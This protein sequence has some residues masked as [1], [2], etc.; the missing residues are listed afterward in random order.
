MF[1]LHSSNKT[2]NL[3]AHLVAIMGNKPLSSPFAKEVFLIQSQGMER[4]LSQQLAAEFKVWGNYSF[5]FPGKF[6]SSLAQKIDSRLSDAAFERHVMQWRLEALLRDL[7][8]AELAVLNRYLSGTNIGLK[9]YQLAQQLSQLFDQYQMMRPD[10]LALWQQNK[11]LY[12][13][14]TERWQ[15]KLWLQVLDKT[16]PRHRGVLWQA[17]IAKLNDAPADKF[18]AVMPERISV[19]G[20]NTMP[21]LFLHYL[22]GLARHCDVH[23]YLLNPAQEFWAD[24]QG[25][26]QRALDEAVDGHPLLATLGQQGREF[27][28]MLLEENLAFELELD[29]F[30]AIDTPAPSLLQRLQNDILNNAPEAVAIHNNDR[31]ISLHSCHSRLREVEVLKNQLLQSLEAD[32]A[33]ELRDIVVMAPDIQ[34]Y[35]P[36]IGAV[37]ADIQHAIADRSLRLS[38]T[39][40]DAF[41]RF[42]S[43]SQSRFGWVTV[44]DLLEQPVVYPSFG[45]SETDLELVKHWVHDTQVRWGKSAQH[46][47]ELGLP[48]QVENT[49]QAA[50]DRL[51]MGYAV[52]DAGD[53]VDGILPYR[54]IEGASAQAL[55]GLCDFIAVLFRAS[56]DLKQPKTLQNWSQRLYYYADQ[57]LQAAEALERQQ[58]N[59]VLVELSADLAAVHNETV[60]LQ[61]IISWIEG[62]VSERKSSNGFLRGQLTFCSMLPMRSIPFKVIALL[63]MNDGEFPKIDRPP[64]F[65]L[66]GMKNHFRKGDRSRRA[67]DRY[68]FLEILLSTRQQLLVTYIGQSISDNA[69]IPPS[70]II[71]ELLDVLQDSYQLTDVVT[72]HPLQPF[73]A[74]YFTGDERLFSFSAGDFKTAQQL[75]AR[76][77]PPAGRT[78]VWWQGAVP[79]T[80]DKVLELGE[81]LRFFRHPQ[82]Y[83]MQRQLDIRLTDIETAAQE[84]EP[85]VIDINKPDGYRLCHDWIQDNLRGQAVS[86]KKLQAQGRWLAGAVG[87]LEFNRHQQGITRFV[88]CIHAKNLGARIEDQPLD[89]RVGDVR[90][91]GKL[92]QLYENGG[93]FYRYTDLKGK[94]FVCAWLQHLLMNQ[95]RPHTTHLL[96]KRHDTDK[97]KQKHRELTFL[98]DHCE[99]D[100]LAQ[101]IA[102]YRAGLQQPDAFFVE[103]AFAY[104]EHTHKL[105]RG[106]RSGKTGLAV[107]LEH[108]ERA[109]EKPFERELRRLYGA[110]DVALLLGADFEAQCQSLLQ[111]IWNK[112]NTP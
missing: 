59:E 51:L 10:M 82:R 83:F 106:S 39:A 53:F 43:V 15:K 32:P 112:A 35:E 7:R 8:G 31:S 12:H 88:E 63:G 19:F 36:F 60:E 94:D 42:L 54:D 70:V 21:P 14:D 76:Q 2:E 72:R 95:I 66:L 104:V 30:E 6:F 87:E 69:T 92:E 90:V 41:I 97:N 55:G 64:T 24:L 48:E 62:T 49:W 74:R 99:A 5:L 34:K 18:S 28:N 16:G 23:F 86:V 67:D 107:A 27:Q 105:A 26:R 4:W 110:A 73:S 46:K 58:L 25:K 98:P 89:L 17:V 9:R 109:I 29:S 50:L 1:I 11:M 78:T 101:F 79:E 61:V 100:A 40:L 80:A 38:N 103:A 22:Q 47:Q 44:L 56:K 65:D 84:R 108:L 13:T 3:V 33:L 85:F 111:P 71:S 45:L 77:Q 102:I 57:L 20:L 96:A 68:Q 81:L 52:G 75:A 37:F 93:L 91:V